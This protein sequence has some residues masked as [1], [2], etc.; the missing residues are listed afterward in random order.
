MRL[1]LP[2][3]ILYFFAVSPNQL[4]A[5]VSS[6]NRRFQFVNGERALMVE[7]VSD[8]VVH[9]ELTP[10]K[11]QQNSANPIYST[12]MVFD[13][14]LKPAQIKI[15]EN[16]ILT[17]NLE[18]SV[19]PSSLCVRTFDKIQKKNLVQNCPLNL[20][21]DWKGITLDM[22]GI[23]N[24]YGLG[25]YFTDPGTA[26]G[27]WVGKTWDPGTQGH[28]N[29]LKSFGGGATSY[30]Q[31]PILY[32]VGDKNHNFALFL[33]QIYKQKW[34]FTGS[35]WKVEMWGDQIRWYVIAGKSLQDLRRTYMR[36]TGLPPLPPKKI[37]GLWVSEF[38]YENWAEAYKPVVTLR[39]NGFPLDGLGMD[40][41]W[42]GGSFYKNGEDTRS[43]RMGTLEFDTKNF[44]NFAHEINHL[45]K[46]RGVNLMLIEESYIS[47]FL[48]GDSGRGTE[49]KDLSEKGFLASNCAGSPTFLNANPWWGVGG[50]IDWTNPGAGDYWHDRKRQ[51]LYNL[52]ITDHWTDLGEPEMYD[53][54]SCYY[55]FPELGKFKHGDIHNIYNFKWLESIARG[56]ERNKNA[57]RPY[58]MARS[59]TS[60]IQR[61][62]AGMWS[63]DIAAN[64]GSLTA[65]YRVHSNMSWAGIDYFSSDVGGFH[66]RPDTLDG[67]SNELFTQWFANASVFD[68]PVRS[69]TWN[70][71]NNLN[72]S[73]DQ[74]GHLESNRFNIWQRYRLSPYYYSLAFKASKAGDPIAPPPTYYYQN[75]KN[76][77]KVGNQKM[78]GP[79]LMAAMVARYG[80]TS[81]SVYLPKG[82][83]FNFHNHAPIN[84]RG[85]TLGNVPAYQDGIFRIPLFARE[86]AILP[87]MHVD[88]KTMNILGKR[89]GEPKNT[90]LNLRIYPSRKRTSF[91]LY[92][93][94]GETT[95]YKTNDSSLTKI[96]Q[97][98]KG[99]TVRVVIFPTKG[100]F[101]EMPEK[102]NHKLEIIFESTNT[103]EVKINGQTLKLCQSKPD[104]QNSL[105]SAACWFKES[106]NL[107]L[108][109]AGPLSIREKNIFD[110]K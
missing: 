91:E 9:F 97:M 29:A 54:N 80:E 26:D 44:G 70:L 48:N 68:F 86:G 35:P 24:L 65:H 34:S 107:L 95:K 49:H 43:S 16:K 3:V 39:Q 83:W 90:D 17:K 74:I 81:R 4:A 2:L 25:N 99:S 37:F 23:E 21:K 103:S 82:K 69:H 7:V 93:D 51:P 73:P 5:Q 8:S 15:S 31:F 46:D 100:R 57:L 52:G 53:P 101:N 104:W 13:K 6:D 76:L 33:D 71:A 79:Y 96:E 22:T 1:T 14:T 59:G 63:G 106:Q 84:S 36:L 67:D 61:F 58:M 66:R 109:N 19:D 72:T 78:I 102:R 110:I 89:E 56:Y 108:I 75:D 87:L 10:K 85:E 105:N 47:Q 92:E 20:E 18:I 60:G 32:A 42:F 94:D 77:R 98:A 88:Q 28:G 30:A 38:G 64:M 62:G 50:M 45:R 11:E 12:P 27:D 55:G 40:L 41:Q